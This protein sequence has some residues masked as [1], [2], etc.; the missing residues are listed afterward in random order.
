MHPGQHDCGN[1]G[2]D[3]EDRGGGKVLDEVRR[4]R[5]RPSR[6][7]VRI[8]GGHVADVG[9]PLVA[10]EIVEDVKRRKASRVV[11]SV[12]SRTEVVS[13][14]ASSASDL[15]APVSAAAPARPAAAMEK[16]V[17]RKCRRSCMFASPSAWRR[18]LARGHRF[19]R[20]V[21]RSPS[22]ATETT[23]PRLPVTV[24]VDHETSTQRQRIRYGSTEIRRRDRQGL[25]PIARVHNKSST[26]STI[27]NIVQQNVVRA[28]QF[29]ER[30]QL[31]VRK[32]N[33]K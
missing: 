2:V 8:C 19:G 6:P 25:I 13:G 20:R 29:R 4:L 31:A 21:I 26:I 10:Q 9:E 5:A 17:L 23:R 18:R 32:R 28:L 16:P 27:S 30:L 15:R 7:G 24:C 11:L 1:A 14:G 22:V 12:R 33:V 3:R